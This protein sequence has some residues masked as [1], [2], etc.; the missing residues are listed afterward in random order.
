M[1]SLKLTQIKSTIG[2]DRKQALAAS[3]QPALAFDSFF[4][5]ILMHELM[6]GLGPQTIKVGGRDT[7]VRQELKELNGPLEEAMADISG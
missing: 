1:K 6:H 4:T 7:T 5:H 2:F 3:D